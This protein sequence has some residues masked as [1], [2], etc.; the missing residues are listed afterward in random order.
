MTQATK[1]ADEDQPGRRGLRLVQVNGQQR[2][3]KLALLD[4][5]A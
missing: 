3:L 5:I 4:D 2:Q 1:W